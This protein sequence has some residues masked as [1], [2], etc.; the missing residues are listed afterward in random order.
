MCCEVNKY[1]HNANH[2][3]NT[4]NI[5]NKPSLD[6]VEEDEMLI[7]R[8]CLKQFKQKNNMYRHQKNYC[9]N[10]DGTN[11]TIT[12]NNIN[13]I[14]NTNI[15][16]RIEPVVISYQKPPI[17]IELEEDDEDII[18]CTQSNNNYTYTKPHPYKETVI[19]EDNISTT[20]IGT[21]NNYNYNNFIQVFCIGPKDDYF[22]IL[23]DRM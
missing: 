23:S 7:C 3:K 5:S 13:R 21:V 15:V 12:N 4:S 22:Q 19:I 14:N 17:T 16:K 2:P 8:F 10:R 1:C 6:D 20:N 18:D 9:K 11:I